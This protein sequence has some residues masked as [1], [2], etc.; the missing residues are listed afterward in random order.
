MTPRIAQAPVW[1]SAD[2][3]R[4][5]QIVQNLLQNACKFTPR[6]GRVEVVLGVDENSEWTTLKV[7][8]SGIGLD[9]QEL[10]SIF[11]AFTQVERTLDRSKG[12]LG[13]GLAIVRGLVQLHGGQVKAHSEGRGKGAE[14][15]VRLPVDRAEHAASTPGNSLKPIQRRRVLIIEDNHDAADSLRL[16]LELLGQTTRVAYSGT[17]GLHEAQ[18]WAPDMVFCDIGLPVVDGYEVAR[19]LRRHP[20]T[21]HTRLVALTGYGQEEDKARSLAAGFDTHLTKPADPTGLADL[22]RT[23]EKNDLSP[24]RQN[25]AGPEQKTQFREA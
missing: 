20:A 3:S 2:R 13:L 18:E 22:L 24:L 9:P 1:I 12:G 19:Q 7:R 16:L 15:V 23:P 6:G 4:V 17:S 21:A 25:D 14:F 5:A 11:E 10:P 8:D